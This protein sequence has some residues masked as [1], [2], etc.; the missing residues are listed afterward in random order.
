MYEI[1]LEDNPLESALVSKG[2]NC[3]ALKIDED[4]EIEII[5]SSDQT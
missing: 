5:E 3:D 4:Y 2:F 1:N